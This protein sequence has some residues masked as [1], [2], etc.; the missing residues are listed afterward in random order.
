MCASLIFVLDM[1]YYGKRLFTPVNFLLT[2]LSSVSLFY[3]S[4]PWHYYLS[5]AIPVLCTT[6]LPFVL[7]GAWLQLGPSETASM[8]LVLPSI[9]WTVSIYSLTGHKEWRFIHPLL[10]LMQVLA[11]KSLVYLY[12]QNRKSKTKSVHQAKQEGAEAS[13]ER[14]LP[15]R[16]RHLLLLMLSIPAIVYTMRFHSRGQ[17]DVMYY[18]RDL[19]ASERKSI[20]FLM[21]CHSTP[22]QSYLHDPELGKSNKLW[23]LGCEPPLS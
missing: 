2:N 7:H 9:A 16:K 17:I 3:G 4:S 21:P 8:G 23:A 14:G 6:S 19:P 18:L 20:G 22:W 1:N 12:D 15:V 5:Q 13:P 11:S 10:P